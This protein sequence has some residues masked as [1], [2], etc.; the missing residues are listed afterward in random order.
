MHF[1]SSIDS[2]APLQIS[3]I[4]E[5]IKRGFLLDA[6]RNTVPTFYILGSELAI[7]LGKNSDFLLFSP[8]QLIPYAVLFFVLMLKISNSYLLASILSITE[9]TTGLTGTQRIFF[10]P[11]GIGSVLYFALLVLFL[12]IFFGKNKFAWQHHFMSIIIG[13]SLVF[14]S[15]DAIFTYLLF[16][17]SFIIYMVIFNNSSRLSRNNLDN[18]WRQS[19]KLFILLIIVELGLTE[20]VYNNFIHALKSPESF[21]MSVLDK[22][23]LSYFSTNIQDNIIRD[24]YLHYPESITYYGYIKYGILLMFLIIFLINF[25]SSPGIKYKIESIFIISILSSMV[26]WAFIRL[27]IGHVEVGFFYY[28]AI[29]SIA[30]V[31]RNVISFKRWALVGA[32][33]LLAL[34]PVYHFMVYNEDLSNRDI[35]KFDYL[36]TPL[37]WCREKTSGA[38][39]RS[40]ELTKNFN[41]MTHRTL[42]FQTLD[43]NDVAF[44]LNRR[45]YSPN[46]YFILNNN[47]KV[48]DIGNWIQIKPWWV[49]DH[50]LKKNIKI[51]K[52]F[53]SKTIFVYKRSGSFS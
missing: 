3:A 2:F 47:L 21:T 32:I 41:L 40:D 7:I 12:L 10:W 6:Y 14:T 18:R 1:N 53:D 15:Y 20:F 46:S 48:L 8:I 13:I 38:E 39:M 22:F 19:V 27:L 51:N 5:T 37:S 33:L 11:H 28:P 52:I 9:L 49:T 4:D 16:L 36:Y 24:I 30:W 31:Y 25:V 17:L 50:I 29:F 42:E 35:D 23:L 43:V 26:A 34:N 45:D 44:L